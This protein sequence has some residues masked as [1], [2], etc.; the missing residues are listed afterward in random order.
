MAPKNSQN[1]EIYDL[2]LFNIVYIK[3]R[4]NSRVFFL[5]NLEHCHQYVEEYSGG[6]TMFF[7]CTYIFF[8]TKWKEINHFF[9]N[10]FF[11]EN[12]QIIK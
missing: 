9:Y 6:L 2:F 8:M 4:S 5:L 10:L 7:F 11:F 1:G 12:D 3:N